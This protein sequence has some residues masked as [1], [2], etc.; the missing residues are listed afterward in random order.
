MTEKRQLRLKKGFDYF[1]LDEDADN[2]I[3][4]EYIMACSKVALLSIV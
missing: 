2:D 1:S 3:D 4:H